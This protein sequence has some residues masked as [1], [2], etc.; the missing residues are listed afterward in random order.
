MKLISGSKSLNLRAVEYGNDR[1]AKSIIDWAFR[2]AKK[3]ALKRIGA[4]SGK[5]LK[6]LLR[7][8]LCPGGY[9]HSFKRSELLSRVLNADLLQYSLV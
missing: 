2:E 8:L 5:S 6:M 3:I 7:I 9:S 1:N 4:K